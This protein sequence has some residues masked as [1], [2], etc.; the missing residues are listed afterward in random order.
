MSFFALCISI[1]FRSESASFEGIAYNQLIS[2]DLTGQLQYMAFYSSVMHLNLSRVNPTN[3]RGMDV[4][5]QFPL[6]LT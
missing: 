3:F 2:V 4:T 5:S 6:P 1:F